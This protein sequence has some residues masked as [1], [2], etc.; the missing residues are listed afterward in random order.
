MK[1]ILIIEDE[2]NVITYLDTLFKDHGY[3]TVVATSG[4]VGLDL[5]KKEKPDLITLDISMPDK[6]GIKVYRTLKEDKTL[7]KI[8][9]V[10]ITGVTGYAGSPDDFKKFLSTRKSVPPPEGFM[11]KPID[12]DA[13]I[14]MIKKLI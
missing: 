9:V 7:Q 8:P 11:P 3:G 4:D 14:K 12:R 1:K 13:L 10:V 6:S 5:A 2:Q